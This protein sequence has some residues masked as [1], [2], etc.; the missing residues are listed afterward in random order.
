MPSGAV[1]VTGA[2]GRLGRDISERLERHGVTVVPL[3]LPGFPPRPKRV[4]WTARAIPVPA[5]DAADLAALPPPSAAVLGHWLGDRRLSFAEQLAFEI[6][7]NVGRLGFLWAGLRDAGVSIL[8]HLSSIRVFGP[9][10]GRSVAADAAP[11]PATP[12]GIAKLAAERFLD[13]AFDAA[14]VRIAHLRLG[15]VVCHG[16][17][18]SQIASQLCAAAFERRRVRIRS[19]CVF[20]P[21]FIDDVVDRVVGAAMGSACGH[22]VVVGPPVTTDTFARQFGRTVGRPLDIVY[23][24]TPIPRADPVVSAEFAPTGLD[25]MIAATIDRHAAECRGGAAQ[26]ET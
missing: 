6:D 4:P 9:Q 1:W 20:Q 7:R 13:A 22:E 24:E 18:P 23:D 3:V 10:N 14:P 12:Y 21:V 11:L 8:V 15:P 26:G 16:G 25:R 5:G 2:T 19:G 17:H